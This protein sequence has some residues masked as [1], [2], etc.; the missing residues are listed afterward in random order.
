MV[1]VLHRI[2]EDKAPEP[3]GCI[4]KFLRASWGIVGSESLEFFKEFH[5]RGLEQRIE[6]L[7]SGLIPEKEGASKLS[8][9]RP[10]SLVRCIYKLLAKVLV[11]RPRTVTGEVIGESEGAFIEGMQI[12]DGIMIANE[13]VHTR[14]KD[15]LP[16]VLLKIDM[17]SL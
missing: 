1:G 3:D 5:K 17:E 12:L 14:G 6:K 11:V 16:G 8:H 10:I 13:L 7:F 9:Y 2:E 15:G 4:F